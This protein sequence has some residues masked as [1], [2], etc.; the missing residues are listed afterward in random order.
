[1][2][3]C[4]ELAPELHSNVGASTVSGDVTWY[5]QLPLPCPA[6]I[7]RSLHHVLNGDLTT[8]VARKSKANARTK[9]NKAML[10]TKRSLVVHKIKHYRGPTAMYRCNNSPKWHPS[11]DLK[12]AEAPMVVVCNGSS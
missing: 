3:C 2:W 10:G 5:E 1:M 7:A 12:L 9:A 6:H 11:Y 4:V 8:I